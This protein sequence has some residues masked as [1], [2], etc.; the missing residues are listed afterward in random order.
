MNYRVDLS[1]GK[2]YI[3]KRLKIKA[4]ETKFNKKKLGINK[5]KFK[6]YCDPNINIAKFFKK[7]RISRSIFRE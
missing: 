6:F 5:I 1:V 2:Q 3:S 7:S 4:K